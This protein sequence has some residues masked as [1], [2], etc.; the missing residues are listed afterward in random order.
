MYQKEYQKPE[1]AV[2]G[3]AVDLVKGSGKTPPNSDALY[4][5]SYYLDDVDQ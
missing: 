2:V 1:I 4:G 5:W 3:D